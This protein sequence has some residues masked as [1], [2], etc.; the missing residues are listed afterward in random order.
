MG[1]ESR[2][3]RH[4]VG[5]WDKPTFLAS[6]VNKRRAGTKINR[7]KLLIPLSTMTLSFPLH[8][9]F[10]SKPE[11]EESGMGLSPSNTDSFHLLLP[12]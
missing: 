9:N 10:K 8:S 2:R 6:S 4:E 3:L 1:C 5:F 12:A 7:I 11:V